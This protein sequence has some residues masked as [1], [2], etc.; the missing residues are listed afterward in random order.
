MQIGFW[1]FENI[2]RESWITFMQYGACSACQI[3]ITG[4]DTD[5]S[6][7]HFIVCCQTTQLIKKKIKEK[8]KIS[9]NFQ[10]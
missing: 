8:H 5:K 10:I 3:L 7:F 4:P 6:H 2:K 9:L 1:T